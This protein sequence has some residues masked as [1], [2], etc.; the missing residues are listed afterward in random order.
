MRL[1]APSRRVTPRR[2]SVAVDVVAL[3]PGEGSLTLLVVPSPGDGRERWSLPWGTT[4]DGESLEDIARR[5]SHGA[6]GRAPSVVGQVAA[7]G[8]ARRHPGGAELSVGYY[9][10]VPLGAA[11]SLPA[12]GR[13]VA[14]DEVPSLSPRHRAVVAAALDGVRRRIGDEP[15]A[16]RL[17]P[18][19]F[20]LTEL[21]S[22]YELVLGRALH[23]A[24]FRRALQGARLVEPTDEW[25]SEGRGRPAQLFRFSQRK[26]RSDRRE[27]VRFDFG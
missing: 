7:L 18:P 13:W 27:S 11:E 10:L 17:L 15:I 8:D 19:V 2:V 24:S 9:A 1:P 26:R 23:K 6:L 25:R 21:Q 12:D 20:T 4:T 3:R 14:L 5:V 22:V 16:F